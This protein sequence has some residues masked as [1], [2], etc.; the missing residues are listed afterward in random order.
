MTP[1]SDSKH[2]FEIAGFTAIDPEQRLLLKEQVT[3]LIVGDDETRKSIAETIALKLDSESGSNINSQISCEYSSLIIDFLLSYLLEIKNSHESE[4]YH[5]LT[6]LNHVP[7]TRE[8]PYYQTLIKGLQPETGIDSCVLNL[9]DRLQLL[10]IFIDNRDFENAKKLYAELEG[11]IDKR[12]L[13]LWSLYKLCHAKILRHDNAVAELLQMQLTLIVE[14]Y[15]LDGPDSAIYYILRWI[16]AINWQKHYIIKKILLMRI[17]DKIHDQK[18]LNCAMVL[19]EL[20]NMED[21][22]VP[23]NEKLSYQKKL[24]KFP[25][26]ILNVQQLQNLYFFAGNYS[27]GVQSHFKDSIQNYQYSNYFLHKS[28]DRLLSLSKFMREQLDPISYFSAMPYL[29]HRIQDLS[30]QVSLQNNA[31]VESLQA[32]FDKIEELYE[33]VGEL[34]LT[35]SLTGLRNRRYLDGNLFQ[36]VILAARHKVPVCF[37]MIDIDFFK[38][39]NDTYGHLAGDY[40]LKEL[41]RL[42]TNEFRKSDI[43]IRYGG[44]EFLVILFDTVIE[45]SKEMMEEFRKKIEGHSFEYRNQVIPI[46][47]SIGI[48]CD[49]NQDPEHTEL[50]KFISCADAA[51]YSA[52]NSGRNKVFIHRQ[53]SHKCQC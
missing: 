41:A 18:S 32:D 21:R 51:M 23:S 22:L 8:S 52:K 35:D 10:Y 12:H 42:L 16:M 45:R 53:Q 37:A 34:S 20:Y 30:N 26:A 9:F 39:V 5:F 19:Y 46:T 47:I 48:S 6:I 1:R 25:A 17:Y 44:E 7:V 2:G 15:Y 38:R 33:K 29:D 4:Y 40:V 14:A 13:Q 3:A 43:S 27:S 28:W 31:Y 36:M 50:S 24:I 11:L 49:E